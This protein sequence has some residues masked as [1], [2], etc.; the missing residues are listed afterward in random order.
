MCALFS[1]PQ[2][3]HLFSAV[4]SFKALPAICR[5]RF[6]MCDVFFFGT[7]RRTDSHISRSKSETPANA[8]N[9]RARVFFGSNGNCMRRRAGV[10]R[11]E[12]GA[13]RMAGCNSCRIG[14]RWAI[15]RAMLG[16]LSQ[17]VCG[18]WRWQQLWCLDWLWR[19]NLRL[20]QSSVGALHT[21]CQCP[22]PFP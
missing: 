8:A 11:I 10:W 6:F 21:K 18:G 16:L 15:R 5:C 17:L 7:A 13:V 19:K 12:C 22:F 20:P 3:E 9:G 1:R 4:T 2:A 14:C